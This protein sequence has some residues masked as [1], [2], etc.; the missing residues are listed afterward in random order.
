MVPHFTERVI[1]SSE[2]ELMV[3]ADLVS[4]SLV[5]NQGRALFHAW[6]IQNG[7]ATAR[8]DNTKSLKGVVLD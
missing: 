4:L 2:E 6:K 3:M 5:H 1:E 8:S 7:I